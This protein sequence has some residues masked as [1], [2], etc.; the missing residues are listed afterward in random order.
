MASWNRSGSTHV[1]RA[2][3]APNPFSAEELRSLLFFRERTALQIDSFFP[4]TFWG[5]LI[6]QIAQREP[7]IR[8]ALIALSDFHEHFMLPGSSNGERPCFGLRQYNLAIRELLNPC[9]NQKTPLI[10]LLCCLLF[11][12]IEVG[13]S[14]GVFA[15]Y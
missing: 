6:P 3:L 8:H 12:T 11:V 13:C 7:S 14:Y 9:A 5:V 4:S 10:Y 2:A 15:D 1:L